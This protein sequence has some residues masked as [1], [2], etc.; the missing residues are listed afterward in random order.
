MM[1][2]NLEQLDVPVRQEIKKATDTSETKKTKKVVKKTFSNE[3]DLKGKEE[4]AGDIEEK[5][6]SKNSMDAAMSELNRK[7]A[8]QDTRCEYRYDEDTNRVAIKVIDKNTDEVI[9]EIPPEETLESIKKI[10]EIAGIMLDE[11]F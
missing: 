5:E 11:K 7:L 8:M 2:M 1:E 9:K 4:K 3:E 10:W 6:P